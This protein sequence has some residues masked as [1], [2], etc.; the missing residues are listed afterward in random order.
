MPSLWMQG[1]QHQMRQRR[2]IWAVPLPAAEERNEMGKKWLD[3]F[4]SGESMKYKREYLT[5]GELLLLHRAEVV[6]R[7]E[8]GWPL[9]RVFVLPLRI[10]YDLWKGT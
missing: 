7:G 8:G 3:H 5:G 9:L 2:R 4:P 6:Q 1:K 10:V